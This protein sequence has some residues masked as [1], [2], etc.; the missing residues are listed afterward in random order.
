MALPP[1]RGF[2][3][4][5]DPAARDAWIATANA[6][7]GFEPV[8]LLVDPA[9]EGWVR[10]K[11]LAGV[12][13]VPADLDD[14]WLRDNGPT[15]VL[16]DEGA[17]TAVNWVFNAW[18][19]IQD[20]SRDAQIARTV[21]DLAK[22]PTLDSSL[23][24]EGGGICVDG[25]GTV[26]VTET[27]QLHDRRNPGWSKSEV[28]DELARTIGA[29]TVIWLERGLM[30]D[31][32]QYRPGLGTNGHVDVLAAF[33]R[34]GVVVVHGQPDPAHHDHA[35]M[36]ENMA[37]LRA[38]HDARGR[39]LSII[40]IDAPPDTVVDGVSIDHSYINFSFANDGIVMSVYGDAEADKN[41]AAILAGLFPDRGIASVNAEPIFR[42]GGGVHCITQQ[43]PQT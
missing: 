8:S 39:E 5:Q 1:P 11:T 19:G 22:V 15:F 31:M 13:L 3:A 12:S 25:E 4:Q 36:E 34:P 29:T 33:V 26:I 9:D 41:A 16:D 2:I 20:H 28:E 27:V 6:V 24:N 35:V 42:N 10:E 14:G 30:G 18:G 17:P 38:A 43:Q 23:V 32:Q 40:T 7:A 21:A 37:R